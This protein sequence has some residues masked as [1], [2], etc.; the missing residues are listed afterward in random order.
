MSLLSFGS[1]KA[2]LKGI[3]RTY[4]IAMEAGAFLKTKYGIYKVHIEMNVYACLVQS[5]LIME[6]HKRAIALFCTLMALK[7]FGG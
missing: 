1:S 3:G 5:S 4:K 2:L 7:Y 6:R